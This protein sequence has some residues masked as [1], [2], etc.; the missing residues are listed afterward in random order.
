MNR[1]KIPKKFKLFGNE[2]IVQYDENK[3]RE[4]E[5]LGACSSNLNKIIYT[6]ISSTG[7]LPKDVISQTFMHELIHMILFKMGEN[8]I[9]EDEKFVDLFSQLLYQYYI[10][11]E[12]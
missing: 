7:T 12:Y 5:A 10:T 9:A 8:K 11:A 6:N 1:F 2:I 4:L 3:S